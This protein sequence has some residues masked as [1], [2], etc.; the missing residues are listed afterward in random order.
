MC[1]TCKGHGRDNEVSE[2]QVKCKC[3]D[4]QSRAF[5]IFQS[6]NQQIALL[7]EILAVEE[8]VS[9]VTLGNVYSA[10]DVIMAEHPTGCSLNASGKITRIIFKYYYVVLNL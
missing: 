3:D 8:S 6:A 1:C 10:N 7:T 9:N 2:L 4:D 5:I